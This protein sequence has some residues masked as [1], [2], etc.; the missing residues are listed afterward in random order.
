MKII[1]DFNTF[2]NENMDNKTYREEGYTVVDLTDNRF[3]LN[4]VKFGVQRPKN[5]RFEYGRP[6]EFQTREEAEEFLDMDVIPK[7][8][9]WYTVKPYEK[10]NID[11]EWAVYKKGGFSGNMKDSENFHKQFGWHMW[12]FNNYEDAKMCA[13]L[14]NMDL[15]WS[16]SGGG[17][18]HVK[19]DDRTTIPSK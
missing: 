1:K 6:L 17:Y 13:L 16:N 19:K 8:I 9:N 15:Q 3:G 4:V 5:L 10:S 12:N 14:G 2:V 18:Y 7:D 11:G